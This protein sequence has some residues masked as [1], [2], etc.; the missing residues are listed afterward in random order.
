M[1]L[2]W[3]LIRARAAGEPV[4]AIGTMMQFSGIGWMALKSAGI[5]SVRDFKGKRVGIHG[6][7]E[8]ALAIIWI[9]AS[10]DIS[11]HLPVG[12]AIEIGPTP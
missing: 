3:L 11:D 4:K 12:T 1:I 5:R 2:T 6:D 9:G 8:T 10:F 7:G